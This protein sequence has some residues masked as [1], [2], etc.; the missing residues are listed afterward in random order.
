MKNLL[1]LMSALALS[2]QASASVL[3]EDFSDVPGWEAN[4][5]GTQSNAKNYYQVKGGSNAERSSN[6]DGLWIDD[7]DGIDHESN[8]TITFNNLF[9]ASLTTFSIDL[10]SYLTD[11]DI[12]FFDALGNSLSTQAVTPTYG[13][14]TM[15]GVYQNFT[16]SSATGIGGFSLIN[17]SNTSVEGNVSIDNLLAITSDT[18]TASVP[19]P[20]SLILLGLGALGLIAQRRRLV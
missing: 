16:V 14:T 4:W 1:A 8:L 9:A 11:T 7:N 13:A 20:T 19:E 5:F 2:T 12:V 18:P 6:L 3:T 17:S 15:P 10:A